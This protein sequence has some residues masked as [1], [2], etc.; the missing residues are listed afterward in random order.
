M[1]DSVFE[2]SGKQ[3]AADVGVRLLKPGGKLLLIGIPRFDR[4][5][6]EMDRLRRRELC[7]QNVRRQNECMEPAI[8]LAAARPDAVER[9]K[10]HVF[11]FERTA[12]AF[13]LVADYRDGVVKA[14]IHLG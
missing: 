13:D 3:E 7:I 9:L 14:M 10:T 11:P 1:L 12:E 8:A 6:F 5:T 2:C 4:M